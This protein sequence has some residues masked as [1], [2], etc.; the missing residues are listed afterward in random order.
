MAG[1]MVHGTVD[2]REEI[3]EMYSS[4]AIKGMGSGRIAADRSPEGHERYVLDRYERQ[5][6]KKFKPNRYFAEK[7]EEKP[8]KVKITIKRH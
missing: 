6:L 4:A 7:M 5:K 2:N 1:G 8:K 3:D